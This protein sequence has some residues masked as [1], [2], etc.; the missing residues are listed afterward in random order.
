M[1]Y[2]HYFTF[3]RDA[4]MNAAE[5]EA[6]HQVAIKEC[7]KVLRTLKREG[8]SLSGYSA[9]SKKQY[10]G[11]KVNGTKDDA[12]EDF[13]I[14]EHFSQNVDEGFGFCKTARKPYDIA[15]VAC[16]AILKYRLGACIEVGS[17]GNAS[18]WIEGVETAA[19]IL[20]RKI[21]NPIAEASATR[22]AA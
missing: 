16:L 6:A 17:D 15:I 21:K 14:R 9:N 19:R 11:L 7:T 4:S 1:G 20:K 12:H 10:G 5:A 22:K 2:T 13:V 3:K 18:N 8:V